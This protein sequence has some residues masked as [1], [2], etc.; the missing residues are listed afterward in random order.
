M[1]KACFFCIFL[2][3]GI[4]VYSQTWTSQRGDITEEYTIITSEQ[5]QRIITA[6][7]TIAQAVSFNFFDAAEINRN[8]N[9][10]RVIRGTRPNLNGYYYMTVRSVPDDPNI[11]SIVIYGNS[12]TGRMVIIFYSGFFSGTISLRYNWK[13]YA[14]QYNQL[15]RLV[16]GE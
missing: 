9:N 6:Q 14:R 4:F 8:R 1:K 2:V 12:N 10:S 7:E 11:R 5:F 13:E 15:I 3:I 16:N